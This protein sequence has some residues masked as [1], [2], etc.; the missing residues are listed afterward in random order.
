MQAASGAFDGY[1]RTI[2]GEH[3]E[4]L[5]RV[6]PGTPAGEYL[7]R[8]W[9][10]VAISSELGDH[11][12][13]T[14]ILGEDLVIF[15]DGSGQVGLVHRRCPHRRASLEFG[16]CERRGIRCCY[17]G[18][19][20][21]VDGTILE[22]P[23]QADGVVS[24]VSRNTRLGAYRTLEYKGLV[25]A[26]LGPPE[27]APEFPVY[28]TLVM[29]GHDMVPY[30]APFACNWLQVQDAILDPLHTAFLHSRV[31]REQ[32]SKGFGEIGEMK[33][34]ERGRGFLGT[35][36]RRVGQNVWVRV[37]ELVLP[38][39]TQAGAAFA[40][41]GTHPCYFGR[42]SFARWVVPIDDHNTNCLAWAIFGE[43]GDP[44]AYN[45]PEGPE[46]IEQGELFDR[47]WQQRQRFPGDREACEG[48]GTITEHSKENLVPSDKGIQMYRRHLRRE[49]RA[50]ADGREPPKVTDA[51]LNPVPTYG[52]D[53]VLQVPR[54][55]NDRSILARY[56]SAVMDAQFRSEE[57]PLDERDMQIIADLKL[58]E[59]RGYQACA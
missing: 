5:V 21:D 33:F 28:D 20:F 32:F 50:L 54:R 12:Q 57:L 15:R 36:T 49:I 52:G 14:R 31:S 37:N 43:R 1:R 53:T 17:H 59:Q 30:Q 16:I 35:A 44:H 46:L 58:I 24:R 39:F 27:L 6:G 29:D 8:F 3:D 13:G 2:N 48:M 34:Y 55:E 19:L 7:R 4:F 18:W 23:G 11:P 25:F 42:S 40:V 22:I 47:P 56:G 26:Y 41:D 10:P 38:N 51:G 45:T 9:H